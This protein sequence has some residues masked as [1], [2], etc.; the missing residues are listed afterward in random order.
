MTM[1]QRL[2]QVALY[3]FQ[4]DGSYDFHQREKKRIVAKDG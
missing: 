3:Q 4:N 2:G 1:R